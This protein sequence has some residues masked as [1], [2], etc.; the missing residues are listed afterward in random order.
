MQRGI[1][2]RLYPTEEQALFL[3]RNAGCCR[4]AY[5]ECLSFRKLAYD[6]DGTS[7]SDTELV[8]TLPS[9]RKFYP[10]MK[11]ADSAS[12]Q[13]AV[14]HLNTAYRNFFSGT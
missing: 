3:T 7:I 10:Y 14:R 5:N 8:N 4:K 13:Q 2:Y 1:R 11:E 12:L 9:L 6:A